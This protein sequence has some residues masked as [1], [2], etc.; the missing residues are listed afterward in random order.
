MLSQ[1]KKRKKESWGGEEAGGERM[2]G[3]RERKD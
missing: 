1:E 2:K 3:K